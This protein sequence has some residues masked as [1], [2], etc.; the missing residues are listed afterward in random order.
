MKLHM[1]IVHYKNKVKD[2]MVKNWLY[3]DKKQKYLF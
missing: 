1:F 3:K 2:M